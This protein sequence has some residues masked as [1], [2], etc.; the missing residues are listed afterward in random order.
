M[1]NA[2][3][4]AERLRNRVVGHAGGTGRGRRGGGVL[5]VVTTGDQRLGGKLVVG[6]ERDPI[7]REAARHDLRP[8]P[9]EDAEL[10]VAVCLEA[11]VPVEMVRLEVEEDGDV[12]GE[13]VD[14]LELEAR[15]LA[16]DPCVVAG[17]LGRVGE[18][19]TDVSGDLDRAPGGT[20]HRAEQLGC[21]RLPVRA[22]DA[23]QPRAGRQQPVAE[24][25][26]APDRDAARARADDE[27]RLRRYARALDDEIHP[28]EQ[29]LLL[30]SESEFDAEVCEPAGI[31]V[32]RPVGAD[33]V[34]AAPR[35]RTRRSET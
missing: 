26:L 23:D 6:G 4:R 7:G 34:D 5:A 20:E 14:V 10:R 13:R 8:C 9:L 16:D 2:R 3:E 15:Q 22:G 11:A 30:R 1:R 25:D 32:E 33:D 24:L 29:R 12:A 35:E 18:S 17:G 31:D 21:G 27:R 19:A 28:F